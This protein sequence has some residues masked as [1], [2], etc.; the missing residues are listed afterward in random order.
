MPASSRQALHL[1]CLLLLHSVAQATLVLTVPP[2]EEECFVIRARETSTLVGNWDML[3]DELDTA[4]LTVLIMQPSNGVT[5]Y[6]STTAASEGSFSVKLDT[7]QK[8]AVCVQNGLDNK[9]KNKYKPKAKDK[10]H[11]GLDRTVGLVMNVYKRDVSVELQD[12][13]SKLLKG[14]TDLTRRLKELINHHTYMRN[15]EATHRELVERTFSHL[16]SYTCLEAVLVIGMALGQ[17]MYLRRFLERRRY[18]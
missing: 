6:R 16:L 10:E 14:A 11:D 4:P 8:L 12:T 5:Y 13:N 15:R 2:Q 3:D 1:L 17:I 18:M 7:K 9:R